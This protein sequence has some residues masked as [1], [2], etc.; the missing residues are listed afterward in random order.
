MEVL[1]LTKAR[2]CPCTPQVAQ[3]RQQLSAARAKATALERTLRERE[4]DA[5][6]GVAGGPGGE[7][8]IVRAAFEELQAKAE[9]LE[10]QSAGLRRDLVR[11]PLLITL[12]DADCAQCSP[13]PK[14]LT[15]KART[16]QHCSLVVH[17]WLKFCDLSW[18]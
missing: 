5:A 2:L 10:I 1:P 12:R 18:T 11:R 13:Y 7:D 16:A 9:L 17:S 8:A 6:G 15:W 14:L 4:Y 3:L